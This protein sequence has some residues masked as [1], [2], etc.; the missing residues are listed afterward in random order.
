MADKDAVTDQD[1]AIPASEKMDL[2]RDSSAS[3]KHAEPSLS[4]G[5]DGIQPHTLASIDPK[6]ERSVV[7]K[8]DL[9]LLPV[10][11][12]MYLFNSLDK[13]NLGN[14]KT[15]GL[16]KSLGLDVEKNQY[17]TILS[18]F[19]VPYVLTAPFLGL[20][21]K[22]Y[23]PN[24]VLPIMMFCFGACT[25]LVVAAHSFA[26]I[27]TLR[28]F[29]GMSESAFFPLVIYYQTMFYRR[30][31]LARR[32][33]IFYA[34]QSIASAFG[35]LLSFGVFQIQGGTLEPWRY[36]FV[37][38]GSCT[39]LFSFFSF[40]YLPRSA[41]EAKFLS[42]QEQKVAFQRIQLD[43]SSIVNEKLDI[44]ES[45]TIFRQPTSWM[46]LA[47]QICLGVPLQSVN[48]FL[49][50]IITRLGYSTVKTNL[51]TVAP[52]VSGAVVLLILS[53]LSDYTRLRFPFVAM[54]FLFT[55]IGMVIFAG[56]DVDHQLQVAYFASF[57]MTWG[58]SAP[59][60]LLDVL[61]N[62]NIAN[63]NKRVLLTSVAVPAANMMGVVSSNIFRNEDR[64]KYIPAL[65]T[66]AAFGGTGLVLTLL[67]GAF[68][69][70][71]NKK[72]DKRQGVKVKPTEIPT[73]KLQDGPASPDFR[74]CL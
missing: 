38:E 72:R 50:Q 17:S 23:G 58:T 59:S 66:T 61:Y 70:M 22:K 46:I 37:I 44:R 62:N 21:G 3:N 53:F 69:I 48:L 26:G 42:E 56:I 24:R 63:E 33:A 6:L 32:L 45:L 10:L 54:G 55:F 35:G 9:R 73:E 39:I 13:S 65:A 36:L 67:F 57:M 68:M 47:I 4:I 52:N 34:A 2:E 27:M 16:E 30:G 1:M 11:A 40:W 41:G 49:P 7:W 31:E 29:L 64:P 18:V 71:D 20:A 19:F 51:Y 5:E 43:S 25:L 8:F 74:W 12:V 28:W 60:V 14:A 15:A